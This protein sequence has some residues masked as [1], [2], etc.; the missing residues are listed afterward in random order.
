MR[1]VVLRGLKMV[2]F[3]SWE[4]GWEVFEKLGIARAIRNERAFNNALWTLNTIIAYEG[5]PINQMPYRNNVG[6]KILYGWIR[7]F[8]EHG[9][10]KRIESR[11]KG[12][13]ML[14]YLTEKAWDV[15]EQYV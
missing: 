6:L 3:V 8:E 1:Y 7:R 4:D 11:E 2:G 9:I 10:V 14:V 5:R 13:P 12:V 15:L